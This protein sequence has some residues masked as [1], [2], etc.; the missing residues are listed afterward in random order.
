M[1]REGA[2]GEQQD[3]PAT[4]AGDDPSVH[5]SHDDENINPDIMDGD[6]HQGE[7]E[8]YDE[9][10]FDILKGDNIDDPVAQHGAPDMYANPVEEDQ[11]EV[12]SHHEMDLMD[13]EADDNIDEIFYDAEHISEEEM[14]NELDMVGNYFLLLI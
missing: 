6:D 10:F 11:E 8:D 13:V 4:V 7:F 9:E 12:D 2:E 1:I 14:D 5:E 3:P